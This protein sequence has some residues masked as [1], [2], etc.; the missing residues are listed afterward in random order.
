MMATY[1]TNFA[2]NGDPNG[3]GL[4]VWPNFTIDNQRVLNLDGSATVVGVP[5]V[6]W[7]RRLDSR[8]TSLRAAAEALEK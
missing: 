7:L 8:Y 5:N 3:D 2:K 1:W 4:P 6:E